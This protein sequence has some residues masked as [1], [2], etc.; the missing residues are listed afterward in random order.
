MDFL[1]IFGDYTCFFF[2]GGGKGLALSAPMYA[3]D[4]N[5]FGRAG[6]FHSPN[7]RDPKRKKVI[8]FYFNSG[9]ELILH[10]PTLYG[11]DI[12]CIAAKSLLWVHRR[13]LGLCQGRIQGGG[14]RVPAT[15]ST[16]FFIFSVYYFNNNFVSFLLLRYFSLVLK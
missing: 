15:P 3:T 10:E 2:L 16:K 5:W 14:R 11:N 9:R 1:L 13:E 8:L 7:E 6:K 12:L 4:N